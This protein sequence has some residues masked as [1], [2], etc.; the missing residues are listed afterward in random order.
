MIL[1]LAKLCNISTEHKFL[2]FLYEL[3]KDLFIDYRMRL[4]NSTGCKYNQRLM[5]GLI[6]SFS[7][8]GYTERFERF[9]SGNYPECLSPD[10]ERVFP[11]YDPGI[12]T[13]PH[14]KILSV[15]TDIGS[16]CSDKLI[17]KYLVMHDKLFVEYLNKDEEQLS[18]RLSWILDN[19][20]DSKTYNQI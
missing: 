3:D 4:V 5:E 11:D 2:S 17:C 1:S 20:S 14:R 10:V 15:A 16:I 7:K 9:I 6:A 18:T 8:L 19:Y 13:F 12:L